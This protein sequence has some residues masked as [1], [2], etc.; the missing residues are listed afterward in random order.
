M[1]IL[2]YGAFSPLRIVLN[3]L[4]NFPLMYNFILNYII[5]IAVSKV[6]TLHGNQMLRVSSSCQI[7]ELSGSKSC[8][9]RE[10]DMHI[11][12]VDC[13]EVAY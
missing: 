11:L 8:K 10:L 5:L 9:G 4:P 1:I 12:Q 2:D 13:G 3:L 7:L 6:A